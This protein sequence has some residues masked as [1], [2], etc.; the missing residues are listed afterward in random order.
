MPDSPA[1]EVTVGEADVRRL[2]R[3]SAPHLAE[4]PLQ[5]AAEGWDNSMWRLGAD[6][7]VRMPRRQAAAR[8]IAHEQQALPALA[9]ALA[10]T[11]VRVPEPLLVGAPDG[12]Y[13]WNWSI[14][15]WL[16]G[17]PAIE[18]ARAD[19]TAWAAQ[20]ARALRHLHRPAPADAPA[21][22]VRGVPLARRD[23]AIRARLDGIG[24]GRVAEFLR[25]AWDAGLAAPAATERVW[26]H[27]DLHPGNLL[28][29]DGWLRAI[30]DFGDVTAGDPAYDLAG[31]WPAFDADGR[32]AFRTAI[33]DRYDAATWTRARAWAA[34]LAAILLHASDDLPAFRALGESTAA[35]LMADH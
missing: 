13:P 2:L 35:E 9:R 17:L 34:A 22:P 14:V 20:L 24:P 5:R 28:V 19:R 21:N 6:L 31:M 27:G 1:S 33:G 29:E 11:G 15:P 8:L 25:A 4:L 16:P 12:R 32:R 3:R 10:P 23:G 26:I 30:I 18:T 7:A